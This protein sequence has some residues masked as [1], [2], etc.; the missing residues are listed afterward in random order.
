M[1]EY[2]GDYLF[3]EPRQ[4]G[5]VSF[6]TGDKITL[7]RQG[8]NSDLLELTTANTQKLSIHRRAVEAMIERGI[9]QKK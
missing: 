6:L 1:W 3:L 2:N 5:G 9:L 4:L 8:T 7:S